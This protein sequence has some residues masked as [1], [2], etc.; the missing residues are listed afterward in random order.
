MPEQA[1][2]GKAAAE[3]KQTVVT[4]TQHN[5]EAELDTLLRQVARGCKSSAK[6]WKATFV[7]DPNGKRGLVVEFTLP[8]DDEAASE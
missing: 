6:P 8:A 1:K 4:S 7:R 5:A 3:P 2:E